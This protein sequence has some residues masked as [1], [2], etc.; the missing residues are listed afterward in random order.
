MCRIN[1]TD[2][3]GCNI[4]T[5]LFIDIGWIPRKVLESDV[6]I[7]FNVEQVINGN[8][9]AKYISVQLKTGLG[10]VYEA[11]NEEVYIFY[12]NSVHYQYWLSSSI[13][14]IIAFC[15][16]NKRIVYWELL[17]KR[18][19]QATD[20]GRYKITI[21]KSHILCK[22]SLEELES[23]IDTYQSDFQLE[24]DGNLG[25]IN[26]EE[27][28]DSLLSDCTDALQ[29]CRVLFDQL[30]RKYKKVNEKLLET[31]QS[32]G[33]FLFNIQ[34][35]Q[36]RVKTY[37]KSLADAIKICQSQLKCQ[38]PIISETYIKTIRIIEYVLQKYE[39][40][41]T[42]D[43]AVII[44]AMLD[45]VIETISGLADCASHASTQYRDSGGYS[46]RLDRAY[47]SLANTLDDYKSD[48]LDIVEYI[49]RLTLKVEE[50][51]K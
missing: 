1:N 25:D 5:E 45:K 32:Q 20:K 9:T 33:S 21:N 29:N 17:K 4:L 23:I 28:I 50:Y 24:E 14:V 35:Q 30:D 40:I 27:Y 19:I 12:F 46:Q 44:K 18:N 13:P 47:L 7:D 16:P 48:L 8:P 31:I 22:E 42:A 49:K 11:K 15:D 34:E 51:G 36:K 2:A 10:N 6:G 3:K 26:I 43:I 39:S 37:A 41:M 38:I